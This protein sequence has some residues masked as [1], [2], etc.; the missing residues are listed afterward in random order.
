MPTYEYECIECGKVTALRQLIEHREK[1][2]MCPCG[3]TTKRIL[4]LFSTTAS[5]TPLKY[6]E[7]NHPTKIDNK[8]RS[9]STAIRISGAGN[10]RL[11]DNIISGFD[12][13]I[14]ISRGAKAD[15]DRNMFLNVRKDVEITDE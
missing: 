7:R 1:P 8:P 15:M 4:S 10:V 2:P 9:G 11:K 12:T 5:K 14:S 13:G 3:A 6:E